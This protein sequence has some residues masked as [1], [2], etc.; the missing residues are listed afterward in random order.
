MSVHIAGIDPGLVHTG[1]V[2]LH[3]NIQSKLLLVDEWVLDGVDQQACDYARDLLNSNAVK[4]HHVFIEDYRTRGNLNTDSRMVAGV[5][6]MKQTTGGVTVNNTGVKQV[7]RRPLM[8][9][10]GVWNFMTPTHHNDLRSAARIAIYGMLKDAELNMLI[11][12]IVRAH[13]RQE[14]VWDVVH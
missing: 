5:A 10:L 1:V 8:D 11:A 7:V 2:H 9:L 4:K 12:D 6:R 13:L 14:G 3:F